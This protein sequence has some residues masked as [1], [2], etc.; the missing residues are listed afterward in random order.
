MTTWNP[1]LAMNL[2]TDCAVMRFF[3]L[4]ILYA[5]FRT[6]LHDSIL[7]QYIVNHYTQLFFFFFL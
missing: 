4:V 7:R 5:F 2:N 3:F 6:F 1:Q